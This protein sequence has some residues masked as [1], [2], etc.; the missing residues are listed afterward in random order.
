VWRVACQTLL[1]L[2]LLCLWCLACAEELELTNAVT[3]R[4]WAA[5][6]VDACA[7]VACRTV[8]DRMFDRL[9]VLRSLSGCGSSSQQLCSSHLA[10][11][12]QQQQQQLGRPARLQQLLLPP[13]CTLCQLYRSPLHSAGVTSS[14]LSWFAPRVQ[15]AASSSRST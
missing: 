14:C 5:R 3:L 8:V 7:V 11:Q 4:I 12:Q 10:Q 6:A 13:H 2:L 9:Q 15:A 1:L